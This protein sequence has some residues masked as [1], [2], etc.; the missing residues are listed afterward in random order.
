MTVANFTKNFEFFIFYP[1][2]IIISKCY[3]MQKLIIFNQKGEEQG[4]DQRL[5]LVVV[6]QIPSSKMS[7]IS[8]VLPLA[9][10]LL[11]TLGI[12]P[13]GFLHILLVMLDRVYFCLTKILGLGCHLL[14]PTF[15]TLNIDVVT[16]FL[17]PPNFPK[18][19]LLFSARPMI[20]YSKSVIS[21]KI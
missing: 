1:I 4:Q 13:A 16:Y 17:H 10:L 15:S 2:K 14:S 21:Q 7:S 19:R 11:D 18:A 20:F 6:Y 5:G 9:A 12:H 3:T 8:R